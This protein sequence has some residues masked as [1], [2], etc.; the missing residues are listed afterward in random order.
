MGR[1]HVR[2]WQTAYQ[3]I[4]PREYLNRLRAEDRAAM[5]RRQIDAGG[6]DGLLVV[7]SKDEV[8]GF[9]AFGRC[10]DDGASLEE[11]QLYAINP[12]PAHWGKGLGRFLLRSATEELAARGFESLVLWVVPA[13]E[14]ARGLYESEGW[15][16]DGL[17]RDEEVLG[18][19][20]TEVRYRLQLT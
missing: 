2:A 12:D 20:V 5:W 9:A 17:T 13:N 8:A 1:V 7:V 19:V 4:M 18:V 10:Q 11:G 6:A 16:T 15:R 3:S 14:R